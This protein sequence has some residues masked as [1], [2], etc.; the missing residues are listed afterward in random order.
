MAD[1]SLPTLTTL[2]TLV[3]DY[4][5]TR[6]ED[7]I[8][9]CLNE[10]SNKFI[11]TIRYVRASNKFQEWDGSVWNDKVLAI[12]GGGTG[13]ATAGTARTSLGLGDMSTQTSSAINITGGTIIANGAGITS[14]SAANIATGTVPTARLGSGAASSATY[15]RGDSTWTALVLDIPYAADQSADFTAAVNTFYNVTGSHTVSLPTVVGNGGKVIGLVMKGTGS[16]VIDPNGAETILGAATYTFDWNQYSCIVLK[17]D[18]NN[19]KWDV[20]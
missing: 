1:W 13:G 7:A 12:A 18:A 15:L 20:I 10:P 8:S 4:L 2:Y 3:L 5:K 16:W 11:G 6:D 17:A 19:S 14:L 9:L